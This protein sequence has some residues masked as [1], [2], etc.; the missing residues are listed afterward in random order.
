[1][2]LEHSNDKNPVNKDGMT[3][4]HIV[5]KYG[6]LEIIKLL[7]EQANDK[8]PADSFEGW[9]P[10]HLAARHGQLEMVKLL[11]EHS[12]DKNPADKAGAF[13]GQ[14]PSRQGWQDSS[15]LCCRKWSSENCQID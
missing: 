12:K 4:L 6:H 5:A 10:L 7:L 3:I 2:L 8:N 1:L 15:S 14:E 13:Q 11:L 9:T